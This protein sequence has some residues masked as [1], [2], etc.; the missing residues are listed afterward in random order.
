ME[1]LR[2]A[3]DDDAFTTSLQNLIENPD[4]IFFALDTDL[5]DVI[6][7]MFVSSESIDPDLQITMDDYINQVMDNIN[8]TSR[9][10]ERQIVQ[11]D[12]FPAGKLVGE[13][14]VPAGDSVEVS[15]SIA[16]YMI[17]VDNT[18]W[19]ITFRTGR[20]DYLS[21]QETMDAIVNSFWVQQ[22]E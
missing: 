1:N 9:V 2:T 12:N 18:M 19:V 13:T 16:V 5:T 14:I 11:F 3:V 8:E 22:Q 21:Y 15:V 10:V 17:R 7:F 6:K 20:Q 4:V